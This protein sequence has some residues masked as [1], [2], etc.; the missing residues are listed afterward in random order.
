MYRRPFQ[1]YL[2]D[3]E[4]S[5]R[6]FFGAVLS[7]WSLVIL[8]TYVSWKLLSMTN[9]KNFRAIENM[10]DN[11]YDYSDEFG[12][13]DGFMIAAAVTAYDGSPEEI[14]DLSVG[15]LKFVV[16][17]WDSSDPSHSGIKFEDVKAAKCD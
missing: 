1:L 8:I 5:Y 11:Y 10:H 2:P 9:N 12:I 16:K 4:A 15:R 7:L 17:N 13:S 6:T 14:T 3:N